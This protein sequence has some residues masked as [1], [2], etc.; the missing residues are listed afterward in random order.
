[1]GKDNH[2][3]KRKG[4]RTQGPRVLREA[5]GGM[6]LYYQKIGA[7]ERTYQTKGR[8]TQSQDPPCKKN[9]RGGAPEEGYSKKK[10]RITKAGSESIGVRIWIAK[11]KNVKP[12]RKGEI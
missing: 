4:I 12:Q 10:G 9:K 2:N 8:K 1:V 11:R 6:P 5:R 7:P 3:T